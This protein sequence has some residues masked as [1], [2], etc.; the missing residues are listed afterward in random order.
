MGKRQHASALPQETAN[1]LTIFCQDDGAGVPSG[2][3]EGLFKHDYDQK[4]RY[5]LFLA[6]EEILGMTE[7][8]VIETGEL[9]PGHGSKSGRP[10]VLPVR[11]KALKVF[12]TQRAVCPGKTG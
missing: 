11:I 3:K 6:A 1:G 5:G 8:S 9:D 12:L 7:L 4:I 10:K 2:V